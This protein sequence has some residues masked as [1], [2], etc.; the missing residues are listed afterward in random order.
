MADAVYEQLGDRCYTAR[1]HPVAL[2]R[3]KYRL[4]L[5]WIHGELQDQFGVGALTIL[6]VA[7]GAGLLA[8]S[9]AALGHRVS[10]IDRSLDSLEVAQRH[11]PTHSVAYRRMDAGQLLFP[12]ERFDVV[13]VMDLLE[14]LEQP[15]AV[16]AEA[17]RVLKP[18]GCLFF[19]T[20]NRTPRAW[21]LASKG[22]GW[23]VMNTPV[24]LHLHRLFLTPEELR[25]RFVRHGLEVSVLRG[26]QPK[27]LSWPFL[28]LL[29]TGRVSDMLAFEFTDADD[30]AYVGWARKA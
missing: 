25:S 10:G 19:H 27:F 4:C 16:L 20:F 7:C 29:F 18:G 8:N 3:A 30:L 22:I 6:D 9:L 14:R 5:P 26:V 23:S 2:L 12:D 11:D 17:V 15:D 21:L 1:D 28:R 24:N 13:C